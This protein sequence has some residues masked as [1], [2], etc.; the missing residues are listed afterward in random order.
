MHG[1]RDDLDARGELRIDGEVAAQLIEGGRIRLDGDHPPRDGGGV[2]RRRPDP[3]AEI[4]EGR[5]V[6]DD[7]RR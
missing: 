2:E 4:D 6:I 5:A 1:A 7:L 3:G